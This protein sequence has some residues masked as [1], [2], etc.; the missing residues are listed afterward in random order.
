MV[1]INEI[2]F[3]SVRNNDINEIINLIDNGIDVNIKNNDGFTGLMLACINGH[4]DIVKLIVDKGADFSIANKDGN[5]GFH[6]AC[7]YGHIEIIKV[8]IKQ[9]MDINATNNEEATGL[10][11]ACEFGFLNIVKK[12]FDLGMKLCIT[13]RC[14]INNF[15]LVSSKEVINYL[16]NKLDNETKDIIQSNDDMYY[17]N[18][19]SFQ[20]QNIYEF[21]IHCM[22]TEH[23][24][25]ISKATSE[26]ISNLPPFLMRRTFC[27]ESCD[28]RSMHKLNF[29]I[30]CKSYTHKGMPKVGITN[31]TSMLRCGLKCNFITNDRLEYKHHIRSILHLSNIPLG[32]SIQ[33]QRFVDDND[34]NDFLI[35][36]NDEDNSEDYIEN[37]VDFDDGGDYNYA[38]F[39]DII[40]DN[41]FTEI[42][43]KNSSSSPSPSPTCSSPTFSSQMNSLDNINNYRTYCNICEIFIGGGIHNYDLHSIGKKHLKNLI[44]AS[45]EEVEKLPPFRML[46]TYYCEACDYESTSKFQFIKHCNKKNHIP[47]YNSSRINSNGMYRCRRCNFITEDIIEYQ[48]HVQCSKHLANIPNGVNIQK[49]IYIETDTFNSKDQF[50]SKYSKEFL[51]STSKEKKLKKQLLKENTI[52]RTRSILNLDKE[53][54]YNSS[55]EIGSF[56]TNSKLSYSSSSISPSLSIKKEM[57][58]TNIITEKNTYNS[59]IFSCNLCNYHAYRRSS[60]DSHCMNIGHKDAVLT[61]TSEEVKALLPFSMQK[62]FLCEVC[63]FETYHKTIFMFHMNTKEHKENSKSS[64]VNIDQ[65]SMFRCGLDCNF[66]SIERSEYERHIQSEIHLANIP[67]GKVLQD[68]RFNDYVNSEDYNETSL[69][70][71]SLSSSSSSS[72]STTTVSSKTTSTSSASLVSSSSP[73]SSKVNDIDKV[74][75]STN[76][77]FYKCNL[78]SYQSTYPRYYDEHCMSK[79]HRE[80]ISRSSSAQVEALPPYLM[81][82]CFLCN[83]CNVE[84]IN[85]NRFIYHMN[86]KEHKENPRSSE[87]NIDKK[88]MFRCGL[89]C[90]FSSIERSEYERHIQSE[91]HLAN[92]PK[93]KVFQKQRFL[94]GNNDVDK[95]I[96]SRSSLSSSAVTTLSSNIYQLTNDGDNISAEVENKNNI[97]E[98]VIASL[99]RGIKNNDNNNNIRS[100]EVGNKRPL[101]DIDYGNNDCISINNHSSNINVN[102]IDTSTNSIVLGK[103]SLKEI[104]NKEN[105]VNNTDHMDGALHSAPLIISNH[106]SKD[107]IEENNDIIIAV[108]DNNINI[109]SRNHIIINDISSDTNQINSL[110]NSDNNIAKEIVDEENEIPDNIKDIVKVVNKVEEINSP[111]SP[112]FSTIPS[113]RNNNNNT[114]CK[115]NC[116]SYQT[117][118]TE[119]SVCHCTNVH[120]ETI[121]GASPAQIK[122][123]PPYINRKSYVCEVC[124]FETFNK[125]NFMLHMNSIKHKENPGSSEVNIDQKSMFR[126]GLDCNFSSIERS[127]YERHIQSEIHLANF[128]DITSIGLNK[129]RSLLDKEEVVKEDITDKDIDTDKTLKEDVNENNKN[130]WSSIFYK[131]FKLNIF[132]GFN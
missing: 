80:E 31:K 13:S 69:L 85:K 19:C 27:C 1:Q 122:T 74:L 79:G 36:K 24:D 62:T 29:I 50:P 81:L 90:N 17:C 33:K 86:T 4:F 16:S 92:I 52:I 48:M 120:K 93:G 91:I 121:S 60:F 10:H 113:L 132:P 14:D 88:S 59:D 103:I 34:Y 119:N 8:L 44:N 110:P 98:I 47:R 117:N 12:L 99:P 126:C 57:I 67:K 73:S 115:C 54:N 30:H 87:V 97:N 107:L 77:S 68:Q 128:A 41:D 28:Y 102:L 25:Y 3:Q 72:S 70:S 40:I 7:E 84:T 43:T 55:D 112:L 94:H 26:E 127:E 38:G 20:A 116:Y 63:N 2:F 111:N 11:I 105:N 49:R 58:K 104:K 15:Q 45:P 124:N 78:C 22:G 82:K 61:A 101:S 37:E 118:I 35:E 56:P 131:K 32:T 114:L 123:L 66:S 95:E 71:S 65:K 6:L 96:L 18:I 39:D 51:N 76:K 100:I 53:E 108:D 106:N 21:D 46:K 89:D 23:K 5:T 42:Y 64:E 83:V 130:K 9:G 75:N 109:A 125:Y 129:K